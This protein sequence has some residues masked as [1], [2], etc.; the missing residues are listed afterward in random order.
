MTDTQGRPL[1]LIVDDEP[2]IRELLE[3]TLARM[4][5]DSRQAG[6]VADALARLAGAAFD[7]CL[8][9]MRLPDGSGIDIVRHVAEHCP[10]TPIAVITAHGNMQTAIEALK[11]GAFDFVSKPVDLAVLRRLVDTALRVEGAGEGS[12]GGQGGGELIGKSPAMQ[13]TRRLIDKLARNQ[14]PVFVSGA[15]GTGKELAAR[16]IHARSPRAEGPFVAVNC[17]AIPQDLM[18]SEFFGHVKGSFTGAVSDKPGLFQAA[19]GGTLF[20]DEVADLP[21]SMQ[22]KLLRAIQE[23]SVR[24]VGGT[25]EQ[26]FDVRIIS[27]SHRDIGAM[28]ESGDFRQDLFYRIHVIELSMA[29]L[30]ERREDIPVTI[31]H[32]LDRLAQRMGDA[33]PRLAREALQA[34]MTYDYPGNVRELENILERATAL[35]EADTIRLEDLQLGQRVPTPD[36]ADDRRPPATGDIGEQGLEDY[37]AQVERDAI[38][39]ALEKTR[40]NRTAAAKLLGITF[41]A[42]RYRLEKLGLDDVDADHPAST[43][44]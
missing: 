18:E 11:A 2:D 15:S 21:L 40:W 33:R 30:C 43:S 1:A 34:L 10:D 37:L 29:P 3:I 4:Q 20:L 17:G 23:K 8:V 36:S 25:R 7:F 14:A 28:V 9:D 27:A 44:D 19:D 24:A 6:T 16:A 12:D 26:P 39:R 38:V 5:I 35:C 31:E 41:R 32:I 13:E 22:V 42:L